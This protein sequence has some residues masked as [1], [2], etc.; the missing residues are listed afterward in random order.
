MAL[1]EPAATEL[2]IKKRSRIIAD[3]TESFTRI[4][5]FDFRFSF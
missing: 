2:K 4:R 1:C 5:F 3:A